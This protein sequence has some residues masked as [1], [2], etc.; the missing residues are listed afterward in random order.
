MKQRANYLNRRFG[1]LILIENIELNNGTNRGGL[2]IAKCDCGGTTE[3][4]A[5]GFHD[6]KSCG[7]LQ[8]EQSRIRGH[9]SRKY[10]S[11]T[12]N[13]D[14]LV[15]K[16]NAQQRGHEPL[17]KDDWKKIVFNPCHYCG[18]TDTRNRAKAPSYIRTRGK[19]LISGEIEKYSVMMNGVDRVNSDTGYE[20]NNCVPCCSICNR[21]KNEFSQQE[22]FRKINL[23]YHKWLQ[24]KPSTVK[25]S[26]KA[27]SIG[28][29]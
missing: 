11:V 5:Y 2:W 16:N 17:S 15:H 8:E 24:V 27:E 25:T 19:S 9:H 1:R 20:L 3:G 22:F 12:I 13:T 6:K 7:C 29:E 21:M 28:C 18:E 14:Y 10:D 26:Q 23:I 4:Y